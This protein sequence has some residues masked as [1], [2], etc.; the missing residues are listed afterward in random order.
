MNGFAITAHLFA[1]IT[2]VCSVCKSTVLK[3]IRLDMRSVLPEVSLVV[4]LKTL[5]SSYEWRY[6]IV[7][8]ES[9]TI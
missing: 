3:V 2:P 5:A 4:T 7:I 8:Q 9:H 6:V 1:L